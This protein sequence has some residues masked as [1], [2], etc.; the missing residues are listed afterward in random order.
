MLRLGT[1]DVFGQSGTPDELM[2]SYGLT[3]VHIGEAVRKILNHT[4]H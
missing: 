1:Q 2:Q 3:S 4:Q